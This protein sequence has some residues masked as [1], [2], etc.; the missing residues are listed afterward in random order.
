MILV[1]NF[2]NNIDE[3]LHLEATSVQCMHGLK[4]INNCIFVIV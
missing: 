2:I 3:Q 4:F 1:D